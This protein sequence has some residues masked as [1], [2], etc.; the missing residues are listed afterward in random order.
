MF[1]TLKRI[2]EW[3][4]LFVFFFLLTLFLYQL[5][6][7]LSD[8]IQPIDQFKEPSGRAVKVIDMGN[9]TEIRNSEDVIDRLKLFYWLGE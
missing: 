9:G 8:W 4:I 6:L 1:I 2:L 5:V 7:I 3:L